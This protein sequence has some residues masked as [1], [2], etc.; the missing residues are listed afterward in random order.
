MRDASVTAVCVGVVGVVAVGGSGVDAA[1]ST[2]RR[3]SPWCGWC[4]ADR[5]HFRR[6]LPTSRDPGRRAI[7]AYFPGLHHPAVGLEVMAG[8]C[9]FDGCRAVRQ[10]ANH[11]SK[12]FAPEGGTIIVRRVLSEEGRFWAM[13]PIEL[14][15]GHQ[16]RGCDSAPT[17][18]DL[19]HKAPLAQHDSNPMNNLEGA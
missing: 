10:S 17:R 12:T 4:C 14:R 15:P 16:C 7:G 13:S 5:R 18:K 1:A 6:G 11:A 19:I 9:L 2:C 8:S 3:D